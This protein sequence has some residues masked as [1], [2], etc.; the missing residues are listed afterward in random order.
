MRGAAANGVHR[1]RVEVP[2]AASGAML[3]QRLGKPCALA[4]SETE[5]WAVTG[6]ANGTLPGMLATIQQWLHDAAIDRV[7][8]HVGEH[9]HSMSRG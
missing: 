3:V 8:I 2:N 4:G 7:A 1:L 6:P 5:G 9:S